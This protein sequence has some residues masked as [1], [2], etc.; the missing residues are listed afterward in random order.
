[1]RRL[2]FDDEN[3]YKIYGSKE[4]VVP[5]SSVIRF[6]ASG[7][8]MNSRR[9]WKLFYLDKDG[10]KRKIHF[11]EGTFQHGSVKELIKRLPMNN[12]DVEI[13]ESY[14][15]KVMEPILYGKKKKKKD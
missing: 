5:L 1:M 13:E 10:K 9:M 14:F 3:I 15:W 7:A 2:R 12:P 4:K 11:V 8:K 6:E